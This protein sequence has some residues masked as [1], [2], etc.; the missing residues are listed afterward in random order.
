MDVTSRAGRP[1]RYRILG[2]LEVYFGERNLAPSAAKVLTVLAFLLVHA[3]EVLTVT[4]L[5]EELWGDCPPRRSKAAIQTY[6]YQLRRLFARLAEESGGPYQD[7]LT[8]RGN[9]YLLRIDPSALDLNL[10]EER[11]RLGRRA[12]AAG[13][14]R[15]A[16]DLF[17]QCLD[18]WRGHALADVDCG[19]ALELE[20]ARLEECRVNTAELKL[21]A[22]LRLGQ[23]DS[24]VGQLARLTS[25][26]PLRE[27]F[28]AQF[29]LALYRSGRRA[30]A[31]SAFDRLRHTLAS[32]LGVDPSPRVQRLHSRILTAD[33]TLDHPASA[34]AHAWAFGSGSGERI[35]QIAV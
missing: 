26:Y 1:L 13:D 12:L 28:Q 9:G 3:N 14:N 25:Q 16:A 11:K 32:E 2:P 27:S 5:T 8:T 15:S 21:E 6:V 17:R 29:M 22:D 33:S 19:P 31:L 10:L 34:D 30:D 35:N 24:A 18:L 4:D 20:I 7:E 23:H